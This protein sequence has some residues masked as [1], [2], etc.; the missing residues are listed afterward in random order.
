MNTQVSP[1]QVPGT[2]FPCEI[3]DLRI[4]SASVLR[5]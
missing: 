5:F 3:R 1:S 2:G 4:A